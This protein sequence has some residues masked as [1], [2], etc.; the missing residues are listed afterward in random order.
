MRREAAANAAHKHQLG[1]RV[2]LVGA[3]G[4]LYHTGQIHASTIGTSSIN[5]VSVSLGPIFQPKKEHSTGN[6]QCCHKY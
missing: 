6:G 4:S 3:I 1:D 2:G 5:G